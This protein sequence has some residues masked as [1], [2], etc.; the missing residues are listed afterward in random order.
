MAEAVL[1]LPHRILVTGAA[2]GIGSAIVR[3]LSDGGVAA[4]GTDRIAA[5]PDLPN[6]RWIE[7]DVSLQQEREKIAAGCGGKIGGLVHTAGILDAADWL[8]VTEDD[9]MRLLSVN[10]AAPFFLT[11]TLLPHFEEDASI[12]LLGSLAGMRAS[13]QTPFYAA[14]KAGLRNVAASL[15]LLLQPRRI[16]VNVVAPGLI[17]TPLTDG[18]NRELAVRRGATVRQIETERAAAIPLGRAG[19]ADDVADACLFLLSRQ[20]A[21]V[22]GSTLSATGGAL[23]GCI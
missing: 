1:N 6:A 11:R 10:L 21:Y 23:A 3:K 7:A 15:A 16:R 5:P 13:P 2:G 14:S 22:T 8:T 18:L 17:D 4:I 9:A 19:T 12:V 20:A